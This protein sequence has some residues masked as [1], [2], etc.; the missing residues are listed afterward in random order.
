V[1]PADPQIPETPPAPSLAANLG[2]VRGRIEAACGLAGR[3]PAG[4]RLLAVT[5]RVGVALTA[6]LAR[7]GQADLGEN[8]VQDLARKAAALEQRGVQARWH[9]IGHLQRNKAR[10]AVRSSDVIHSVDSERLLAALDRVAGEEGRAPQVYLEVKLTGDEGRSGLAP[11]ELKSAVEAAARTEHLVPVGLM[12][13]ALPTPEPEE[14][15]GALEAQ[16]AARAVFRCLR[17]LRDDLAPRYAEAFAGGRIE[18][19]MGMSSDLEAAVVEGADV[20][21]VGTALFAGLS[22]EAARP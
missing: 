12:T 8:R 4:V 3:D 21:R 15:A 22:T 5:K 9:M 2:A 16:A 1:C 18:L 6:E 13:M 14:G 10:K 7:L 17:E 20:V 11:G 19:S